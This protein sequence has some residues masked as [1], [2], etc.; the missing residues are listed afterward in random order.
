[1]LKELHCSHVERWVDGY[2]GEYSVRVDGEVV[3][4]RSGTP[5]VMKGGVTKDH[6]TGRLNYRV[7]C[8]RKLLTDTH[9]QKATNKYIHRLLVETFLPNLQNKAYVNHKDGNKINND[10]HNLEWSTPKENNAHAYETGLNSGE[11]RKL[12]ETVRKERANSFINS[13][14]TS[15]F[16]KKTVLAYIK[17][18]DLH[19][20][21]VPP[22][23]LAA[24][25]KHNT[26]DSLL[27]QWNR[28]IDIFRLCDDPSLS[29]SYIS[30]ITGLGPSMV[31][32]IRS[33]K[34]FAEARVV[35]DKYKNNEYYYKK[36]S[37]YY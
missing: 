16:S 3:S 18:E 31:S 10:L 11:L 33:G 17:P 29:L 32:Y 37:R 34:R 7:V 8:L 9:N 13:G 23:L 5:V 28:L 22:E 25:R 15:G 27:S 12:D 30:N 6:K 24:T 1:M 2:E 26:K 20:N 14:D 4:Y 21:H 35:Y 19:D 36:Y